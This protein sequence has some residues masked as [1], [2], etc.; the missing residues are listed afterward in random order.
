[1]EVIDR[2]PQTQIEGL[3]TLL[4]LDDEIRKLGNLR[5]FS[6]FATNETHRLIQYH[7]AYLWQIKELINIRVLAQSGTAEIDSNAPTIQWVKQQIE[8]I[9]SSKNAK[10]IHQVNLLEETHSEKNTYKPDELPQYLLWCPLFNKANELNGGLILFREKYFSESEIKMLQWLI[11]SYQY[12]WLLLVKTSKLPPWKKFREKPY[13]IMLAL[14][15]S[16]ILFFPVRISVLG[17]GT[18]VPKLPVLINAPMQ[19]VIKSFAVSPGDS[20]QAGQLLLT[21]DK[22]DLLSTAEVNKKDYLLTQAK[23]RATINASFNNHESNAEI[24]ILQ[25][26]LAIDKAHLDYTNTLLEKSDIKSPIAGIVV[27]D[28]KEDWVNQPVQTGE[29][30]LV[31]ADPKQVKLK[32]FLP[33]ADLIKL[34][35]GSKGDF[36][37]YGQL[38]TL[39][40][41][42]TT[43][44]YNAKLLPNKILAYQL[45]AEFTN[46]KDTPQLG[47]QGTVRLYGNRVPLIYYLIRRPLQAMRQTLGI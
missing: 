12:T 39:P 40:L 38:G 22:S 26:Q 14:V 42:I 45:S 21:L 3:A 23:L 36:F 33:V 5:E 32:V 9:H 34:E 43:L 35:V 7:T 44:G 41:R 24:P 11:A 1:M 10:E 28:S 25:A 16:G 47:A 8:L 18:V 31:V 30:I 15:V 27:F 20:V 17:T 29:R 13:F 46:T 2:N 19:G 37:L 6:F 4:V